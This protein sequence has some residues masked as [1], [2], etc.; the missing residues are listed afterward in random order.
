[1]KYYLDTVSLRKM[2]KYLTRKDIKNDCFTSIH[3]ICELLTDLNCEKTFLYKKNALRKI[4][5]ND[6]FIDWEQPHKKHFES[7]GFFNIQYKIRKDNVLFFC[8]K[9][10]SAIN[11]TDF[12]NS[13]VNEKE[14]YDVI[15]RYDRAFESYFRK[16]MEIKINDF[17]NVYSSYKQATSICDQIIWSLKNTEEGFINFHIAMCIKMAEDLYYGEMNIYEKRTVE[18]IAKS[19]NGQIDVFLIVSGIYALTKI[20]RKEQLS[21]NDFN[22][23]YHLIY[24]EDSTMISDDVIFN[25]YMNEVYPDKIIS[26]ENFMTKYGL[27]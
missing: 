15:Q 6:I 12:Y 18:E 26:C 8:E 17:K 16:E 1:M 4:F 5:A 11:L 25:K 19:Y 20:P 22:D 9:I 3:A 27:C 10:I 7:F 14:E 21:R 23:L 2:A 13:I 24:V